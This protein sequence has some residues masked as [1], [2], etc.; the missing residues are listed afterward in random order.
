MAASAA[1]SKYHASTSRKAAER[2]K[3][4]TDAGV[5]CVAAEGCVGFK[6]GVALNA[7]PHPQFLSKCVECHKRMLADLKGRK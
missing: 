4:A 7:H 5:P 2:H 6:N 3:S 1:G